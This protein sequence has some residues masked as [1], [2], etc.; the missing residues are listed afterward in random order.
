MMPIPKKQE[1]ANQIVANDFLP[2]DENAKVIEEQK[3][4]KINGQE[5]T[6][7]VYASDR[8]LGI[9]LVIDTER[10]KFMIIAQTEIA[11]EAEFRPLL[12]AMI[13]SLETK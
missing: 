6:R 13:N 10:F 4:I 5:A 8:L 11:R 7:V 9:I 12:E 3:N 2:S 1:N